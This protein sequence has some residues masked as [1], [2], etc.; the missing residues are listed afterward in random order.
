MRVVKQ[1]RGGVVHRIELVNE[2]GQP[3]EVVGRF[4]AHLADRCYS[5][6][7]LSAYG[8]DLRHLFDFLERSRSWRELGP[9]NLSG[10]RGAA[11][12]SPRRG[13]RSPSSPTPRERG[14]GI[15]GAAR[16]A[17]PA[18]APAPWASSR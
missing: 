17:R 15:R 16:T 18:R 13:I 6:H 8:Y 4:L 5:P 9:I 11:Q 1:R 7:T 3:V 10:K 14:S 2:E 12:S